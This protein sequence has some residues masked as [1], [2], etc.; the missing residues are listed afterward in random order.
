MICTGK[1]HRK[2]IVFF[3]EE[4]KAWIRKEDN[5][6]EVTMKFARYARHFVMQKVNVS[7]L[8]CESPWVYNE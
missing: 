4:G 1:T 7:G 8:V 3:G 5:L 6:T 2:S